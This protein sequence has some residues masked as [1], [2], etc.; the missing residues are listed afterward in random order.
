MILDSLE[1]QNEPPEMV[2]LAPVLALRIP[3]HITE[4]ANRQRETFSCAEDYE[5]TGDP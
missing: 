1:R 3:R 5:W 4:L 2:R